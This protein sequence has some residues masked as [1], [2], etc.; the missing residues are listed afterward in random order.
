MIRA[1]VEY[2]CNALM[3]SKASMLSFAIQPISF[4]FIVYVIS[5]GRLDRT[6]G[7]ESPLKVL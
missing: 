2:Y 4:I 5:G 1:I 3:K 6:R 7:Y